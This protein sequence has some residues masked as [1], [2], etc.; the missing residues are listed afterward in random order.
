MIYTHQQ[1]KHAVSITKTV[2]FCNY[3]KLKE[4]LKIEY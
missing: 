3:K 1:W 4:W 2:S